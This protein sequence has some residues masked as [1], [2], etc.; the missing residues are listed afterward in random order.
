M[1]S[2]EIREI[3]Q[4]KNDA[5]MSSDKAKVLIS[6]FGSFSQDFVSSISDNAEKLLLSKGVNK[7]LVKRVFSILIEGLQNIRLHGQKDE[8]NRQLGFLILSEEKTCFNVSLANV[9]EPDDF[10]KVDRYIEKINSY[11]K[12]EL[13]ETYLKVLTNEFISHKGGAGLGFITTRIKSG[14]PLKHSYYALENG[15]MLFTFQI[16]LEK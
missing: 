8:A 4:N 16:K 6:H 12:K 14:Q 13:K 15:S 9:I 2:V 7:E 5:I 3:Y 10:Q 11:T 1:T